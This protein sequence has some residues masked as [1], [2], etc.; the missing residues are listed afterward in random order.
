MNDLQRKVCERARYL[1]S[2]N[3]GAVN[4]VIHGGKVGYKEMIDEYERARA[5]IAK[6]EF[7]LPVEEYMSKV[8]DISRAKDAAKEAKR[9]RLLE[10]LSQPVEEKEDLV[11]DFTLQKPIMSQIKQKPRSA[12]E[13]KLEKALK[14][15]EGRDNISRDEVLNYIKKN[16]PKLAIVDFLKK[17]EVEFDIDTGEVEMDEDDEPVRDKKGKKVHIYRSIV[18]DDKLGKD[19]TKDQLM[20]ALEAPQ[21]KIIDEYGVREKNMF[22]KAELLKLAGINKRGEKIAGGRKVIRVKSISKGLVENMKRNYALPD[23]PDPLLAEQAK[24]GKDEMPVDKSNRTEAAQKALKH[25]HKYRKAY[26]SFPQYGDI[27]DRKKTMSDAFK[28]YKK[29]MEKHEGD[30]DKAMKKLLKIITCKGQ[31]CGGY[32][33]VYAKKMAKLARKGV[34]V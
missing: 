12:K 19:L 11:E 7:A 25:Y 22:S 20:D 3:E 24:A 31:E 4:R 2:K 28:I 10:A 23:K 34:S 32:G 6:S 9:Q 30:H 13:P 15:F 1:A 16:T 17:H 8:Q 21:E 18:I 14:K 33:D 5:N 27:M 26:S 29:L